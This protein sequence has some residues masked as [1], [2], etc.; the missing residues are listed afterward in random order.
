MNPLFLALAVILATPPHWDIAASSSRYLPAIEKASLGR[1]PA[2][3]TVE[4]Q[5]KAAWPELPGPPTFLAGRPRNATHTLRYREWN[6]ALW[7]AACD[8]HWARLLRLDAQGNSIWQSRPLLGRLP[9][10]EIADLNAD[11]TAELLLSLAVGMRG[12]DSLW[13]FHAADGGAMAL[14]RS[15]RAGL[16]TLCGR[17]WMRKTVRGVELVLRREGGTTV[18]Q[19]TAAGL[20]ERR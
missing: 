3:A 14:N 4:L 13:L 8:G 2:S 7:A 19:L 18:Y 9:A 16:P 6:G 11:G 17:L 1:T 15:R 5:L 12:Q 20:A 10:L